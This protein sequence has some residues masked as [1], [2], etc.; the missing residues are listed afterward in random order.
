MLANQQLPSTLQGEPARLIEEHRQ[1]RIRLRQEHRDALLAV[2]HAERE[3]AEALAAIEN[4]ESHALAFGGQ[5]ATPK[6][7]KRVKTA[8]QSLGNTRALAART[9]RAIALVDAE[10]NAVAR[11]N[12]PKLRDELLSGHQRANELLEAALAAADAHI[13]A[14]KGYA[15]ALQNVM[16][17]AG[18]DTSALVQQPRTLQDAMTHELPWPLLR[19]NAQTDAPE[20]RPELPTVR[21]WISGVNEDA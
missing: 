8:E 12:Y 13:G 19:Q 18:E 7:H 2:D 5:G 4:A 15:T 1:R 21:G 16:Q 17:A 6:H 10:M 3:H 20:G 9:E 14:L 11:D